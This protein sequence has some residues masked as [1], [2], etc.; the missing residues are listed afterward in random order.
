MRILICCGI[1][2]LYPMN[3]LPF[4]FQSQSHDLTRQF[5]VPSVSQWYFRSSE[6]RIMIL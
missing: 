3:S 4:I 6:H 1:L 5:G 2:L